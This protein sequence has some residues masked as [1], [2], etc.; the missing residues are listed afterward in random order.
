ML[1]AQ[2]NIQSRREEIYD[3]LVP[4]EPL[5]PNHVW[6]AKI[7]ASWSVGDSVLPDSLGMSDTQ[8]AQMH[9]TF[10]AH[11]F[12]PSKAYS[13][14]TSDFSQMP[15]REDLRKLLL[16]GCDN[17]NQQTVWM[18]ELI[19]AACLGADHLWQ[20]LGL[21]ARADL[22]ALM[23]HNF[24]TLAKRNDKNMRWKKFLYKQMC[25]TEGIYVCRSP[26]CEV[27]EEFSECFDI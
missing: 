23:Q 27:C 2:Q 8:F 4:A 18:A 6:L 21:W 20:D 11:T 13:R 17:T 9:T 22:T 7:I 24:P 5:S 10:F 1:L 25:E 15:E 26:S 3:L 16:E 12:I 19:I 14:A